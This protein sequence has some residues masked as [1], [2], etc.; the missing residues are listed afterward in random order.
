[1]YETWFFRPTGAYPFPSCLPTAYAV[2]YKFLVPL[3]GFPIFVVTRVQG[4]TTVTLLLVLP[5]SGDRRSSG[6]CACRSAAVPNFVTSP[7]RF[8]NSSDIKNSPRAVC[9]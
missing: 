9:G 3:R 1:M 7:L 6:Y 4:L 2:G 5:N 8:T